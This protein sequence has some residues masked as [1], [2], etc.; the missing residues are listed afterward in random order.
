MGERIRLDRLDHRLDH[1]DELSLI[2]TN[3]DCAFKLGSLRRI[4]PGAAKRSIM[5]INL[6]RGWWLEIH[7]QPQAY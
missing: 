7:W 1:A 3:L 6:V 2:I 4:K 5:D